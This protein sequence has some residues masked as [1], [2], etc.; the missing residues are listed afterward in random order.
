MTNWRNINI[1]F[2]GIT[3]VEAISAGGRAP[4][5]S[6]KYGPIV[7]TFFNSGHRLARLNFEIPD[8]TRYGEIEK[9]IAGM[10]NYA[11]A[12]KLP[13]KIMFRKWEIFAERTDISPTE[14]IPVIEAQELL[15]EIER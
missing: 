9:V 12:T 15:A 5:G 1:N 6:G 7:E 11:R 2:V 14:T 4:R 3:P 10:R 13:V 8:G